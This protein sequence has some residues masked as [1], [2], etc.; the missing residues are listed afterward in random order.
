VALDST[1]AGAFATLGLVHKST[2]DWS[3]SERALRRALTLDPGS[4]AAHQ[5]YAELLIITG[6]AKAGAIEGLEARRLDPLSPIVA[7][8]LSYMLA[9]SGD[10]AGAYRQGAQA[11]ALAPDLWATHAFLGCAYLFGG[12]P[13]DAIPQLGRAVSL[14]SNVT[15]FTGILAYAD[16][17]GGRTAEARQLVATLDAKGRR[18]AASP[19]GVAIGYMG[20]GDST[21]ALE[22]FERAARERDQLLLAIGLTPAWF[23]PIR[24]QPRFIAAAKSLGL[25]PARRAGSD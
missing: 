23:D 20:L 3:A 16:A 13:A 14:D 9:L 19:A 11:V 22:W 12:R 17:R 24:D 21:R 6:H 25:D 5:W 10:T 8:E 18:G 2:G 4:A 15:L 1:N 7:A